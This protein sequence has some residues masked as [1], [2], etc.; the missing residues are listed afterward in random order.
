MVTVFTV[1]AHQLVIQSLDGTPHRLQACP[2]PHFPGA[3]G[4]QQKGPRM[5]Q[6]SLGAPLAARSLRSRR[7]RQQGCWVR[8]ELVWNPFTGNSSCS[9]CPGFWWCFYPSPIDGILGYSHNEN[10]LLKACLPNRT[11]EPLPTCCRQAQAGRREGSLCEG[12]GPLS[13]TGPRAER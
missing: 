13:V 10:V 7:D 3:L 11:L 1:R 12:L 4:P 2:A 9:A 8:A 5:K 6:L